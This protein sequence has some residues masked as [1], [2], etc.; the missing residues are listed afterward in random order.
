MGRREAVNHAGSSQHC[1][2]DSSLQNH[3]YFST[4]FPFLSSGIIFTSKK[5]PLVILIPTA[6][7][8]YQHQAYI[9]EVLYSLLDELF[10]LILHQNHHQYYPTMEGEQGQNSSEQQYHAQQALPWDKRRQETG[11]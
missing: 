5:Y 3:L 10:S 6:F 4:P 8:S 9:P 1:Q 2:G 11:Q 7:C